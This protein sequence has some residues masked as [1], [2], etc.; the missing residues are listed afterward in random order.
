MTV[1]TA[2]QESEEIVV[3]S[4][5]AFHV[6]EQKTTRLTDRRAGLVLLPAVAAK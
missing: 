1:L 3:A 6:G 5:Q 4:N 2:F